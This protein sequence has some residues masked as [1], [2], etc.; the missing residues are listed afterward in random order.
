M[1][2][3]NVADTSILYVSAPIQTYWKVRFLSLQKT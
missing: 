1:L 3:L 2:R